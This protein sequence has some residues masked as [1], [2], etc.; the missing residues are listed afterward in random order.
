MQDSSKPVV[1]PEEQSWLREAL[2]EMAVTAA[3]AAQ[4]GQDTPAELQQPQE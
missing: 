2:Q 3:Q 4:P 1:I